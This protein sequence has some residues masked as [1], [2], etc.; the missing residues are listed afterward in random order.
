MSFARLHDL[1]IHINNLS[2]FQFLSLTF[3]R[4][5]YKVLGVSLRFWSK[6]CR[7]FWQLNSPN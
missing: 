4:F 7:P 2:W 6:M 1:Y 3:F 5:L